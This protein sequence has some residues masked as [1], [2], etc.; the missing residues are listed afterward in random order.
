M[1]YQDALEMLNLHL[2]FCFKVNCLNKTLF[3]Y[4]KKKPV[5]AT[6]NMHSTDKEK[7]WERLNA[8]KMFLCF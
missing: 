5:D 2:V 8:L 3:I 6:H 7:L 4:V 1:F